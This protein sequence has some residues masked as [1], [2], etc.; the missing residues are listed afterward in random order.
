MRTLKNAVLF[1]PRIM[2]LPEPYVFGL[3]KELLGL[4]ERLLVEILP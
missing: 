3:S 2:C 4:T 1:K